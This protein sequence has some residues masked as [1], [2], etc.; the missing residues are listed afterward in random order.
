MEEFKLI[1][2]EEFEFEVLYVNSGVNFAFSAVYASA[3]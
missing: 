2:V 1:V 3:E